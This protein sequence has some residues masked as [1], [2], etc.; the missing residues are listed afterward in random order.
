MVWALKHKVTFWDGSWS[1]FHQN[2]KKWSGSPHR[3][4]MAVLGFKSRSVWGLYLM[5]LTPSFCTSF[6]FLSHPIV[7]CL[8][9]FPDPAFSY[10][11]FSKIF[12]LMLYHYQLYAFSLRI[13]QKRWRID[14][15]EVHRPLQAAGCC[16]LVDSSLDLKLELGLTGKLGR[17]PV[18]SGFKQCAS[19]L[20]VLGLIPLSVLVAVW[21]FDGLMEP[22]MQWPDFLHPFR[23]WSLEISSNHH[24]PRCWPYLCPLFS[25]T[26]LCFS[27]QDGS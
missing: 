3:S 19:Q 8:F 22:S 13:N 16:C 17:F 6:P 25:S 1:P 20:S 2:L 24:A 18:V 15:H 14:L 27:R 26:E 5:T 7:H 21:L 9:L 23:A 11:N 12:I 10:Q 4:C